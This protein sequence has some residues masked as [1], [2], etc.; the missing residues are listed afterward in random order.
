[1][2]PWV[3]ISRL[4]SPWKFGGGVWGRTPV[5]HNRALPPKQPFAWRRRSLSVGDQ[6]NS[7]PGGTWKLFSRK[8]FYAFFELTERRGGGG[9]EN[10]SC[11]G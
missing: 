3:A 8:L 9:G 10:C 4:R 6:F 11:F 7:I 5:G 2:W 1:M